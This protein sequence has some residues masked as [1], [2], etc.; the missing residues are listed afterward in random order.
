VAGAD[1]IRGWADDVARFADDWPAKGAEVVD[2]AITQ[3]LRADSGDGRLSHDKG[4]GRATT[5]IIKSSGSADVVADGSRGVW[6]ILEGGTRPHTVDAG[7]GHALRTPKG[8]RR[9]VKVSGARGKRTFTEGAQRGLEQAAK[10][11]E[12]Q[13]ARVG[14]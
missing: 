11:A 12:A 10:D 7:K 2:E 4:G 9:I 5:R 8:P 14:A 13:W 6:G 1:T 3:R